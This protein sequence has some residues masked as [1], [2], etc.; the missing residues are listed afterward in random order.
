MFVNLA[1]VSFK[2]CHFLAET[3]SDSF[4]HLQSSFPE[5]AKTLKNFESQTESMER[6][7]QAT[8]E[9]FWRRMRIGFPGT[10]ALRHEGWLWKHEGGFAGWRRRYFSI[11]DHE[12]SI[13]RPSTQ[14]YSEKIP[15][16][17]TSV[18]PCAE[19]ERGFAFSII[20]RKKTFTVQALTE[21]DMLEWMAIIQNNIQYL[22]DRADGDDSTSEVRGPG[23]P[24]AVNLFCADCGENA[25]TWCCLNWG[26]CI[27]I[28]CSGVHREMTSTVSKV[29]SLTL[30]R[31]DPKFL[32]VFACIGNELGNR[33]LEHALPL[34]GKPA[35]NA[36]RARRETFIRRK[37]SECEFVAIDE[38]VDM[39]NAI[40]S[41]DTLQV[42]RGICQLRKLKK[43]DPDILRIAAA[44]GNPT[45]CLIVGLNSVNI[46]GLDDQGWSALSY[47]SF[48]GRIEAAEALMAI[49]CDPRSSPTAHPYAIAVAG[50]NAAL[51]ALFLPYWTDEH[52]PA[53]VFT[54]LIPIELRQAKSHASLGKI[55]TLDIIGSMQVE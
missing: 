16:M 9:I 5:S 8:C 49:G 7:L 13:F 21:W 15:L 54:P 12:L 48:Y 47:A 44:Y 22:L 41:D 53:G 31:L 36:D 24:R 14:E 38:L 40:Q 39:R 4:I 29:R 35:R 19:A 10:Q 34:E 50:T 25:P 27:C 11:H 28:N 26:T 37:Y 33:I 2:Q 20:T 43:S 1:S 18:K 55:S 42:F 45:I 52:R 3:S 46:D 6:T 30:D 51:S 17:L 32:S 23:D